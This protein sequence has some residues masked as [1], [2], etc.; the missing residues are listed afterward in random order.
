[1]QRRYESMAKGDAPIGVDEVLDSL[2]AKLADLAGIDEIELADA[3]VDIAVLALCLHK[4][5]RLGS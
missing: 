1:M 4:E 3:A 5:A 2:A